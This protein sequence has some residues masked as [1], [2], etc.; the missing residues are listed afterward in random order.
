MGWWWSGGG[1]W[2]VA[3]GAVVVVEW[4]SEAMGKGVWAGRGQGKD[5][6]GEAGGALWGDVVDGWVRGG[7]VVQGCVWAGLL[8]R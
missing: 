8:W 7:G 6:D 1:G 5:L 4:C 2:V 3:D